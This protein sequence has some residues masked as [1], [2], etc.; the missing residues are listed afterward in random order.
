MPT[1]T[2]LN[3]LLDAIRESPDFGGHWNALACWLWDNGRDDEAFAVRVLWPTLRDNLACTSVAATLADV[4]RNAKVLAKVA[5]EV[6]RR[7]RDTQTDETRTD[8]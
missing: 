3:V 4:A 7:D 1:P 8:G 5:R 6:E 2:D